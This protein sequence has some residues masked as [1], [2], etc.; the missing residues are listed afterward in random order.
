MLKTTSEQGFVIWCKIFYT[1]KPLINLYKI[2]KKIKKQSQVCGHFGYYE[3]LH[4]VDH[5]KYE[6]AIFV[7]KI[8]NEII[9]NTFLPHIQKLYE[10]SIRRI[11]C[12]L[13]HKVNKEN[14][15]IW[16]NHCWSICFFNEAKRFVCFYSIVCKQQK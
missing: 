14:L 4:W 8:G 1:V 11:F 9:G 5:M 12:S 10:E 7:W 16:L 13:P 15:R 6:D 2:K 3:C